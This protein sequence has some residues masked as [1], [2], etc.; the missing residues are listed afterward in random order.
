MLFYSSCQVKL[1]ISTHRF[2]LH[3]VFKDQISSLEHE[4]VFLGG[5]M[6]SSIS[7][8]YFDNFQKASSGLNFDN[9]SNFNH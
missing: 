4:F 2:H 1:P 7:Y 6:Q 3:C 5:G 8:D 9:I